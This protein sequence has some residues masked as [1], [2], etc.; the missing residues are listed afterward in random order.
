MKDS[1]KTK[2]QLIDE[3]AVLRSRNAG[4][5]QQ[6]TERRQAEEA[7]RESEEKY[8]SLVE[9]TDDSIYLIDRNYR[10]LFMNKHHIRRIGIAD[11]EYIGKS[12]SDYHSPEETGRFKECADAV[13]RTG[14]SIHREYKSV[15]DGAYLLQT[16]SPLRSRGKITAVTVISQDISRLKKME[17][18]L[19]ALSLSDELTGIYNRRGLV[20]LGEQI[21]RLARRQKQVTYMLYADVDNLKEINDTWGHQEGD[22]ML[23]EVADVLRKSFRDSDIISRVGGDEFVVIPIGIGGDNVKKTVERFKS[24]LK[25]RN[26]E[27]S[28]AYPLSVS[29]GIARYDPA[30]PCSMDELLSMADKMMYKQKHGNQMRRRMK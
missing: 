19:R 21:L 16:W 8:R 13:F 29:V 24:G 2:K 22:R 7:L 11:D 18:N 5:E 14:K 25:T 1:Y 20:T 23:K 6:E 30:H 9:S 3:I 10:Y 15:R 28:F 12:Y 26:K 4:L 27:G 17:E